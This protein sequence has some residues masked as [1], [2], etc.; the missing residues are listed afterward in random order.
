MPHCLFL[1][2]GF[3]AQGR[4]AQEVTTC[5]KPDGTGALVTASRSVIYAYETEREGAQNWQTSISQACRQYV[6]QIQRVWSP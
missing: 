4:T 3:G 1:V 6:S 2:P 5:F